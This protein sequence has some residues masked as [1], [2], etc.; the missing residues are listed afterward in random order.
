MTVLRYI[1]LTA[2]LI[3]VLFVVSVAVFLGLAF[4]IGNVLT[5]IVGWFVV[6]MALGAACVVAGVWLDTRDRTR[7]DDLIR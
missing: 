3:P 1:L 5:V 2:A 6:M 4:T 7:Q